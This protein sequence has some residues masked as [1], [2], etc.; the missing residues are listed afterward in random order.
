MVSLPSGPLAEK[1]QHRFASTFLCPYP[2]HLG[3]LDFPLEYLW[4]PLLLLSHLTSYTWCF[5]WH[6]LNTSFATTNH[7]LAT[8][9]LHFPT[10]ALVLSSIIQRLPGF[11]FFTRAFVGRPFN[12]FNPR[13][14]YA[15][16][17]QPKWIPAGNFSPTA[18][19]SLLSSLTFPSHLA[20]ELLVPSHSGVTSSPKPLPSLTL[21]SFPALPHSSGF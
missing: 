13:P 18:P 15:S 10:L 1:S 4:K 6:N 20:L 11:Q 17:V 2:F 16:L 9:L 14:L 12:A 5:S 7:Y 19:I 8:A 3:S 21:L